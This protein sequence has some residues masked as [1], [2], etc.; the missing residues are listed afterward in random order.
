[1]VIVINDLL[2]GVVTGIILSAVKLLAR[3][4][5]LDVELSEV[6]ENDSSRTIIKLVGAATFLRLPRLAS[7]LEKVAAGA[8]LHIDVSE[9][10]Y[11]DRAC[12]ELLQNW[13]RQHSATGGRLTIDWDSLND[14]FQTRR[15]RTTATT[16]IRTS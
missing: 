16:G 3:F 5:E 6:T 1:L 10:D 9:M 11:I 13:S 7:R 14:R 12:M 2:T 15:P 4:S 8:D